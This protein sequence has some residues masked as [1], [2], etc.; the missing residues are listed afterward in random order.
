MFGFWHLCRVF[1]LTWFNIAFG[2]FSMVDVLECLG[3]GIYAV[4]F[5]LAAIDEHGLL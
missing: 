2:L 5:V 3:F 1:F 4:F